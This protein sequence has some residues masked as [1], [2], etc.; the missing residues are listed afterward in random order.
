MFN[1]LYVIYA[2]FRALKKEMLHLMITRHSV[3]VG[4]HIHN[5]NIYY[6]I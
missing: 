5:F 1:F 4:L 2:T 6:N 3:K